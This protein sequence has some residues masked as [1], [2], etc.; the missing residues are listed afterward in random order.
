LYHFF[1][2]QVHAELKRRGIACFY[3]DLAHMDTL[4]HAHIHDADLILSTIPDSILRGTGNRRLLQQARR[5]SPGAKVIVTG[6]RVRQALELYE[7][8]ADYVFVP[9]LHSARQRTQIVEDGL[10]EGFAGIRSAHITELR[11]RD[12]VLS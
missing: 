9:H 12:E 11:Q 5:L 2:P 4:H 7:R 10:R 3:G 6:E 1:N 8:G